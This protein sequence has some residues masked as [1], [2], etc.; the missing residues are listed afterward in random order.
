MKLPTV[1]SIL[2]TKKGVQRV[3]ESKISSENTFKG[4]H[5]RH[6]DGNEL[7]KSKKKN[8]FFIFGDF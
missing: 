2:Q 1:F 7:S 8:F 5:F 4:N 6:A 3:N